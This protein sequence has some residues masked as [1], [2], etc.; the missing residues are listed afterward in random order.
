MK[1]IISAILA[2]AL[3]AT[4]LT[5]CSGSGSA[6][7][8]STP[9]AEG[10]ASSA[11][12]TGDRTKITFI[13]GFTGGDGAYMRKIT[14]EFNASQEAYMIEEL[15]DKDHYTKFK[16]GDYDLVVMHGSNLKT[17]VD[18][19]MLQD[20]SAV[21]E[22]AGIKLTDFHEAGQKIVSIDNA[23]YAIPLDVH[24][25]TM[26]YNKE[27]AAEAPKTLDDIK[28]LNKTVQEKTPGNYAMG[29][30]GLGLVEY[31]MLTL[32]IQ[33]D[34]PLTDG[35][36]MNFATDGF[37]DVLLSLNQMI[38]TDKL[39][40]ANLGL[41]GEFKT[42]VQSGD[43]ESSAQTAIAMTGPWYYS[44]AKEKF[45]DQ[46]GIAPIPV[47]GKHEATY[48]NAHTIALSSDVT[49]EKKLAGIAEF[50]KYMYQPEVLANWAD[51]GQAPMH[52][53]T[54]EYIAANKDKYPLAYANS[55]Q[56][57]SVNIAPQ[58]YNFG[59]QIR[60]MNESVFNMVVSTEGLTKEQLMPELEKATKIAADVA[61]G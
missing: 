55:Q 28:A 1:K 59:E 11:A 36:H 47:L 51:A 29:I 43:S 53:A 16:T 24:P 52:L 31:Y 60:Y 18:D 57:G 10:A 21:Y 50:F 19:E 30:P 41:D 48:G 26:F 38:F 15:Q 12:P 54:T 2:A 56:L 9:A 33:N 7:A 27:L 37:A 42:F 32:A 40:P 5:A 13:N 44:A 46:L 23:P 49:D 35:D 22:A 20:M 61:A 4:A 39:S 8:S 14:E 58:V 6:P 3:A 34:V 17:Y 45:G 25:L